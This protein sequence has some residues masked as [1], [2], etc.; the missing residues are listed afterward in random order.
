M[1]I[2]APP[3][4]DAKQYELLGRYFEA[5]VAAGLCAAG[6]AWLAA[7]AFRRARRMQKLA[8]DAP[9]P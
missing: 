2:E 7:D 1:C 9:L 5:L 8:D 4:Y 3:G 6:A